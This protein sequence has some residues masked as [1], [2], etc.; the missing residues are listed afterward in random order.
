MPLAPASPGASGGPW[1]ERRR[2]I[3][4][5]MMTVMVEAI[6]RRLSGHGPPLAPGLAGAKG[7]PRKLGLI[8]LR[9]APPG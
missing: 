8:A 6:F 4:S 7:M 5:T 2:K 9:P 3:A 1:P